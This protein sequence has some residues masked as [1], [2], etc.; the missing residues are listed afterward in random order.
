M[1]EKKPETKVIDGKEYIVGDTTEYNSGECYFVDGEYRKDD[2]R[3]LFY[4]WVEGKYCLKKKYE[5][6]VKG[7]IWTGDPH[8]LVEGYFQYDPEITFIGSMDG[9]YYFDITTVHMAGL[10]VYTGR[11]ENYAAKELPRDARYSPKESYPKHIYPNELYGAKDNPAFDRAVEL[12]SKIPIKAYDLKEFAPYSNLL[13]PFTYGLEFE[14]STGNVPM[15]LLKLTGLVPVKDGS[16]SGHEY[17]TVPMNH[18]E[19][20][21][22]TLLSASILDR[23]TMVDSN[24]S[25][26][27]HI[28]NLPPPE[29]LILPLYVLMYR[30]QNELFEIC[31]PYKRSIEYMARK[32]GGP[33]DHCDLLP[34][35]GFGYLSS[36]KIFNNIIEWASDGNIGLEEYKKG[37]KLEIEDLNK[38]RIKKR[39][40]L[41]QFLSYLNGG[42]TVEF[43]QHSATNNKYKV[44]Y[45]I[46]ICNA[47]VKYAIEQ[48]FK[49]LSTKRKITLYDVIENAYVREAKD[50]AVTLVEYINSRKAT[51]YNMRISNML[52]EDDINSN[53]VFNPRELPIFDKTTILYE[54]QVQNKRP[55]LR[56]KS[57]QGFEIE[58]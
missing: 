57:G 27:V 41:L 40:Y 51:H 38:W 10:K 1:K 19:V 52:Y 55:Q 8:G 28:G 17:I 50:L 6:L 49:V 21:A 13:K 14:T 34:P 32:R 20:I 29:K 18:K 30:I 56:K 3:Y 16:I 12:E 44:L 25:L 48:P 15:F 42:P 43:R 23:N 36:E 53:F 47:I 37:A 39:Y 4:N 2:A 9:K 58:V 11:A 31:A 7:L 22:K 35:L 54:Q 5:N 46:F 24:C 45:W 33:K 26:H